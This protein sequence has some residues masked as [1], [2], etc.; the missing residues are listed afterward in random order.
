MFIYRAAARAAAGLTIVCMTT[1]A[2][3]A[4]TY[5][6]RPVHIIVPFA[7]GGASDFVAR[8]VFTRFSD[9]VG[10]Q[11]VIDNRP[12]AAGNIAMEYASRAPADGYTVFLGN[13][14]TIAI[15]P[16]LYS[17]LKV[18]P[19]TDFVPVTR[20]A[21]IPGVMVV[22][23]SFPARTLKELI[24]IAGK[25]PGAMS[26]GSPGQGSGHRILMELFK[27]Q[28]AI[29]IVE[30]PYKGGAGPAIVGVV[31]GETEVSF[32][33]TASVLQYLSSGRLRAIATMTEK[34][35]PALS[36][37][38]TL[39]ELGFPAIVD[40]QWQ[41]IFVPRG[42]PTAVIERLNTAANQL[43]RSPDVR[44]RLARGSAEALP[45][46]TPADFATFVDMETKRW[47]VIVRDVGAKID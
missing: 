19:A 32:A 11:A 44:E 18:K 2:A 38:P 34:R 9:V 1:A 36:H 8:S 30:V 17:T 40:S 6:A 26:Y 25:K 3:T 23:P 47:S 13:V 45:T 41:G 43:L 20:L 37:V 10:Q 14:G 31:A 42:T 15:N 21:G 33:T 12:G 27:K 7:P 22:H 5:P 39:P 35:L 29:D 46:A 16:G 24:A 28:A 4:Q